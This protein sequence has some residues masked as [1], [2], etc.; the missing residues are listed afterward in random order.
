MVSLIDP[1][2]QIWDETS[3]VTKIRARVFDYKDL[4]RN[5][6]LF[7]AT[8]A[9]GSPDSYLISSNLGQIPCVDRESFMSSSLSRVLENSWV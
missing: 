6:I 9:E 1:Q 8:Y 2:S 3:V 4:E 5:G 7:I